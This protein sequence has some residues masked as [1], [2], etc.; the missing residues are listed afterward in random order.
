MSVGPLSGITGRRKCGRWLKIGRQG[1]RVQVGV[2]MYKSI[3]V[4]MYLGVGVWFWALSPT[5]VKI[6]Q[7]TGWGE[8]SICAP[9]YG[10][11]PH[12]TSS[13][14]ILTFFCEW[15]GEGRKCHASVLSPHNLSF[16]EEMTR[17]GK[18]AARCHTPSTFQLRLHYFLFDS[19]VWLCPCVCMCVCVCSVF[20]QGAGK[21]AAKEK[22]KEKGKEKGGKFVAFSGKKH[23]L[24]D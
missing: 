6:T 2:Q 15:R 16:C 23:L 17:G 7:L 5:L 22:E 19:D 9:S 21:E 20:V 10:A 14:H 3:H 4:R 11:T 12:M 1:G 18:I 24:W 8:G 13:S